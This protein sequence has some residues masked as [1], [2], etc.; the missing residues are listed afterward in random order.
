MIYVLS[1]KPEEAQDIVIPTAQPTP[2]SKPEVYFIKYNTRKEQVGGGGYAASG[3]P[4]ASGA[5]FGGSGHG[6]DAI[7]SG[8]GLDVHGGA[9]GVGGGDIGGGVVGGG[10]SAPAAPSGNYGPPGKSGPY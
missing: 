6:G 10:H 4:E 7:G 2:P 5:A 8:P 9:G 1:K 3:Q